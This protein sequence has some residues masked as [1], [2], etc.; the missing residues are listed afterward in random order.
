[1]AVARALVNEPSIVLADEPSGNLDHRNSEMLHEL[2]WSLARENS[3]SFVIVTHDLNL[4]KKADHV[5]LLSDGII[6][7]IDCEKNNG[8]LLF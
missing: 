2:I 3:Y 8:Q 4:A 1:M 6:K 7:E 5:M